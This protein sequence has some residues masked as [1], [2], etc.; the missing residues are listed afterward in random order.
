MLPEDISKK[1]VWLEN[2]EDFFSLIKQSPRYTTWKGLVTE[3]GSNSTSLKAYRRG[4]RSIDG[5]IFLRLLKFLPDS[6]ANV[7]LS[8]SKFPD[9]YWGMSKGGKLSVAKKKEKMGELG[10]LAYMGKMRLTCGIPEW[11]AQM[12]AQNPA[13]YSQIQRERWLS[14]MR[15]WRQ[16][17]HAKKKRVVTLRE[18]YGENF[19]ATL[20][21]NTASMQKLS[22]REELVEKEI[23]QLPFRISS[24]KTICGCNFD[25]AYEKE[26]KLIAV[27]EVLGFKK[28]K[29]HGF[30]DLLVLNE[31]LKLLVKDFH[32]PFFVSSWREVD[33]GYKI[34]R[35]SLELFLWS[36]EKGMVPILMDV[37]AFKNVRKA[38]LSGTP[39]TQYIEKFLECNLA[40]R[41]NLI[42][43]GSM[44]Q[45][46]QEMDFLEGKVHGLLQSIGLKPEGKKLLATKY[47]TFTVTDN[48]FRLKGMEFAVF[49]SNSDLPGIIGSSAMA[50][51]MVSGEIKTVGL[52]LDPSKTRSSRRA[53]SALLKT[54]VDHFYSSLE[55]LEKTLGPLAQLV[56]KS[57]PLNCVESP[58][59]QQ[60]THGMGEVAGSKPAG[61]N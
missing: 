21:L 16:S 41:R 43:K 61:S 34:E 9:A 19:F 56:E 54:Y 32:V 3:S 39:C 51:E 55:E 33:L 52:I 50:K 47:G 22:A 36:L 25:F 29:G 11:H 18:R 24:H 30:Y 46:N 17:P 44:A 8:Q 35:L 4:H 15:H 13:K 6:Q 10:F 7:I 48:Y 38:T 1:R 57:E 14:L 23:E 40:L 45:L 58:F 27:E 42:K 28:K 53:D 31:K 20:G 59:R 37:P 60:R 5:K 2:P 49:V 12:R 26:G